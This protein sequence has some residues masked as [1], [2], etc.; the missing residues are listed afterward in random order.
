M[1][2]SWPPAITLICSTERPVWMAQRRLR[3]DAIVVVPYGM[4]LAKRIC[5]GRD[6]P[7]GVGDHR[8]PALGRQGE[9]RLEALVVE[10]ELLRARVE[11]DATRA[12]PKCA[13]R[14]AQRLVGGIET[15]EGHQA[16]AR[17]RGL[18]DH[19]VV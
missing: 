14:L 16:A 19:A 10:P 6:P 18:L 8:Q 3:I 2:T 11:L 15:A 9:H 13:L 1:R 5:P 4:S 7:S 12:A 17:A